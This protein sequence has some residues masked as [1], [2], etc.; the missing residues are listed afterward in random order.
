ME[1]FRYQPSCLRSLFGRWLR[2]RRLQHGW[3]HRLALSSLGCA[4]FGDSEGLV[5][6]PADLENVVRKDAVVMAVVTG[7]RVGVAIAASR[8]QAEAF[9]ATKRHEAVQ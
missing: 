7:N 2:R 6:V 9:L 1:C 4:A 5:S 8:K 3:R